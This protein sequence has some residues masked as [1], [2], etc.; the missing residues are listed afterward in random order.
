M[1]FVDDAAGVKNLAVGVVILVVTAAV[2]YVGYKA[3]RAVSAVTG[4]VSGA[5]V[6]VKQ[7][8]V[9]VGHAVKVESTAVND[10]ASSPWY[11]GGDG[12]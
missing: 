6:A 9:A 11:V 1:A 5:A 3:Y 12:P 7:G 8:A 4:A 10:L 2:V